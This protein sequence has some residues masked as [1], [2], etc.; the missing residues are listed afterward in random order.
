VAI[1]VDSGDEAHGVCYFTL[2]RRDG[3]DEGGAPLEGQPQIVGEYRDHFVRT[4]EGWRI[5]HRV[6]TVGFTRS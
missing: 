1:D 2:Y 5:S 3:V 6:A 4:A